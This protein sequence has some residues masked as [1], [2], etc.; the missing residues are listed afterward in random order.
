MQSLPGTFSEKNKKLQ[1]AVW[2][3]QL[4]KTARSY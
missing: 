1:K 3:A 4:K 2:P